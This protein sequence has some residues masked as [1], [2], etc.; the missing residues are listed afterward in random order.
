VE[1][2]SRNAANVVT[3][4]ENGT[5]IEGASPAADHIAQAIGKHGKWVV[6]AAGALIE[7][8]GDEVPDIPA[9]L[10]EDFLAEHYLH[11]GATVRD[12]LESLARKQATAPGP[13][14]ELGRLYDELDRAGMVD[15]ADWEGY[16]DSGTTPVK[17]LRF[18]VMPVPAGEAGTFVFEV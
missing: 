13:K 17:D 16:A 18:I 3:A 1:S 8:Y 11:A 5:L 7:S 9:D 10:I 15:F 2:F 12:A 14:S 6:L 4:H